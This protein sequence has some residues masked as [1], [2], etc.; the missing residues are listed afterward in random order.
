LSPK[1][2][3]ATSGQATV[4]DV[5][6]GVAND[7]DLSSLA[8]TS[9]PSHGTASVDTTAGTI[10][11]TSTDDYTGADS[12]TYKLCSLDDPESC[13]TAVLSFNVTTAA[14]SKSDVS[15]PNTGFGVYSYNPEETLDLTSLVVIG[16]LDLA[17]AT[18]KFARR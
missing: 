16:L 17:L 12:L 4:V 13:S 7:P 5:V 3:S 15:A 14:V 18:R 8:I 11:Y 2:V 6:A 9:D 10:T 1:T